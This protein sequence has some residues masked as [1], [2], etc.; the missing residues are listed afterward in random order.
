MAAFFVMQKS[1]CPVNGYFPGKQI[2][3]GILFPEIMP[4]TG[5]VANAFQADMF[6]SS[7]EGCLAYHAELGEEEIQQVIQNL[8]HSCYH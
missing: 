8:P 6:L 4:C 5:K 2:R 7:G 3:G 1:G